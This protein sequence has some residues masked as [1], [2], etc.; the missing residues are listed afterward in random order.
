MARPLLIVPEPALVVDDGGERTLV[1]SDVHV[2]FEA[3][4]ALRGVRM[5]SRDTADE[6]ARSITGL[7]RAQDAS[8]IVLL[9]DT[10]AG[11]SKISGTEWDAVPA[12]LAHVASAAPTVLVPGNHDAGIAHLVPDGVT[13]SAPFGIVLGDTLL[14]HGH[15]MPSENLAGVLRIVMGHVHPVLRDDSSV[16]GGQR[17]W[18]SI[19]VSKSSVFASSDGEL[20]ITVMPSYNRYIVSDSTSHLRQDRSPI[21]ARARTAIISAKIV[22]L[23]GVIVGD[24]SLLD[25][26]V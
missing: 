16:I 20:E 17:V 24:E 23:G 1:V 25:A 14:T 8:R 26:V 9:G 4:M 5:D 10:K 13:V 2:G 12:F 3:S 21:L 15:V 22:T 7:A 19:R 6:M 11:T 18:A